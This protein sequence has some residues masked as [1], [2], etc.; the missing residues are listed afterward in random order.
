MDDALDLQTKKLVEEHLARCEEC[1][2][3]SEALRNYLAVL[4]SLE[5]VQAPADFLEKV[6]ER[7]GKPSAF[8]RFVQKW[9][10]PLHV[11]I[12]MELAGV[13]ATT[14]L[15]ILLYHGEEQKEALRR[16]PV[17][18]EAPSL[19]KLQEKSL[20]LAAKK[21]L[22]AAEADLKE[23][24]AVPPTPT[25]QAIQPIELTLVMSPSQLSDEMK[26]E[27]LGGGEEGSSG[28]PAP[29]LPLNEE[30]SFQPSRPMPRKARSDAA[31]V[32][33]SDENRLVAKSESVER[34]K[35]RESLPLET[36][37]LIRKLVR[38]ANGTVLSVEYEPGTHLPQ[39]VL[40]RLPV[41]DYPFFL[42]QL[43]S[44]GHVWEPS[45][46][47]PTDKDRETLQVQIRLVPSER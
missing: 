12:P 15:V 20:P 2:R 28:V 34:K 5:K 33:S 42:E 31:S 37:D 14:L 45:G 46:N 32:A 29:A 35:G 7:I 47:V 13:V 8:R 26:Q 27:S 36:L 1:A 39:F 38:N 23:S 10:Y 9:F 18:A 4:S 40:I 25:A 30:Q 19:G 6:R 21:D 16:A 3:E 24:E 22:P 41:L 11:K 44:V 43:R 17:T